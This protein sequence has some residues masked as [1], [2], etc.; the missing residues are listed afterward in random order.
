M[1]TLFCITA[2]LIYLPVFS[3]K[4]VEPDQILA[5][6]ITVNF[7]DHTVKTQMLRE[8][9]KVKV[10]NEL[11]Y[12]WYQYNKIM[13]TKG[14]YDGKLLHGYYKSFYLNNQLREAGEIK[15]GVK[16]N[17]WRYWYSD[18][19]LKEVSTWKNGRKNG[20][21]E[22]FNDYG[23]LMAK[24]CFK[25]DLLNGKFYTYDNFGN[26]V[27]IKKYRRGRE[28]NSIPKKQKVKRT[29]E[30]KSFGSRIKNLL[31]KKKANKVEDQK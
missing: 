30:K 14:G 28:I 26:I 29:K 31:K 3:Q 9:K 2:F 4:A 15:Y 20:K 23:K 19:N 10:D 11:S 24:G 12:L 13:E 5:F 22:L 21:Y 1:K 8:Q 25:D 18:G 17:E 16:H 6:N 7:D 27:D